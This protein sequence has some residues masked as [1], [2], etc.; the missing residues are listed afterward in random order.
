VKV[1]PVRNLA[2]I[3]VS[4]FFWLPSVTP[5]VAQ[6]PEAQAA[7]FLKEQWQSSG[8]PAVSMAV[9]YKG[10]IVFSMGVGFA[11]RDNLVPANSS[12]VYN[13]GSVSKIMTA[14]AV[15]QL[16]EQGKVGLDDPIQKFVAAFPDKGAV[17]T[18]R[19]LLTHTSGIRHYRSTDFPNGLDEENVQPFEA[20]DETIRVFKNDPLLFK[21]GAFYLY[22]SYAVNLLQGVIENASGRPFESY[23]NANVWGPAGMLQTA[24]AIPSRIV[25]GRA[26]GY[27]LVQGRP[28][29]NPYGDLTYKFAS[30]GMIATADDLVRLGVALNHGRLLKPETS[31]LMF[32]PQLQTVL[33]FHE[34]GPPTREA[35]Q[36]A[37]LWRIRIDDAGREFVHHCGTVQ[38]FNAC[39]VNYAAEDLVV[40]IAS[41][42]QVLGFA[43]A[44]KV[45]DFFRLRR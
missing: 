38:G 42:A 27:A 31:A 39:L 10:K 44:L 36:Q 45:A 3:V 9:A 33:A 6:T 17:I 29:N 4:V 30:G 37:L 26:R 35:F 1:A 32:T 5:A 43:P 8:A 21:P 22:S 15:M 28:V 18:I 7:A 13:I 24:F 2:C 14:V 16:V 34:K 11:D 25:A 41:N 40:A 20:F 23:M 19:H 12:T